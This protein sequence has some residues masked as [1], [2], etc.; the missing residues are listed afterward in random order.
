MTMVI[1]M[2]RL[3]NIRRIMMLD[4]QFIAL[5][6]RLVHFNTLRLMIVIISLIIMRTMM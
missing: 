1:S 3:I 4:H 6:Y 5:Y 2:I